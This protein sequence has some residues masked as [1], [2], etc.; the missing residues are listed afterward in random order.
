M[1]AKRTD[2]LF[3]HFN[4]SGNRVGFFV[5][6][7]SPQKSPVLDNECCQGRR[8]QCTVVPYGRGAHVID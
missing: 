4:Y 1:H 5:W 8:A 3:N 7:K 2:K 6:L